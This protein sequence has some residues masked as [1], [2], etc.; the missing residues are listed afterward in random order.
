MCI[1]RDC[2]E[3][4][5]QKCN[6]WHANATMTNHK[7]LMGAWLGN[8]IEYIPGHGKVITKL[9]ITRVCELH[10]RVEEV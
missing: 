3:G 4:K 5:E 7:T 1:A 8:L 2:N 10:V 9:M 6:W